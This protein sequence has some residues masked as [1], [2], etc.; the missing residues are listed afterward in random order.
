MKKETCTWDGKMTFQ[1]MIVRR[2]IKNVMYQVKTRLYLGKRRRLVS[3]HTCQ[4]GYTRSHP[5]RD[6]RDQ[7]IWNSGLWMS[8]NSCPSMQ[9]S[10]D[11]WVSRATQFLEGII[12]KGCPSRISRSTLSSTTRKSEAYPWRNIFVSLVNLC[13]DEW[14]EHRFQ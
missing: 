7:S 1:S 3:S 13:S 2:I 10:K 14:V 9:D 5:D 6:W 8:A 11:L 4:A 12:R